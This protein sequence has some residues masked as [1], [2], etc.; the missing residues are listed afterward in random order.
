MAAILFG[1]IGTLA[2]TS[3]A[4]RQAFN[5][6]FDAHGLPWHWDRDDYRAMLS[7]S[8]GESRI[9]AFAASI[10]EE[11]DAAAIH[12]TK[13]GLFQHTLAESPPAARPGV[14]DAV[15][16]AKR[17]GIKVALVTT[18]SFANVTSLLDALVPDLQRSDFDL[19]V[20][21]TT[22]DAP[23]PD[24][25]AYQYALDQLGEAPS[26]CVAIEDNVAGVQSATS[27]GL[28]CI[29]FPNQN[30]AGHTFERAHSVIDVVNFADLQQLVT[31]P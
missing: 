18:T 23:K 31:H 20:D 16:A 10:G 26:A 12:Q 29:A 4:Q 24:S 30:T 8:G 17:D 1:S 27:A 14:V 6:A 2:D 11:V 21:S 13:S 9:A 22:V 28:R 25:A 15:R 19:L 3:E 7:H 5:S